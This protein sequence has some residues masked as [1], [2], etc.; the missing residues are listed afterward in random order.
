VATNDHAWTAAR[1][2]ECRKRRL[3]L[4]MRGVPVAVQGNTRWLFLHTG[5]EHHLPGMR[6][7][8]ACTSANVML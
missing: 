6:L 7:D 4:A 5:V 2:L 1:G 3:G 8:S